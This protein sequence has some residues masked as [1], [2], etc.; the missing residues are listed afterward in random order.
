MTSIDDRRMN[1][2]VAAIDVPVDGYTQFVSLTTVWHF[3]QQKQ[4][5]ADLVREKNVAF[6][7]YMSALLI[8]R[9][10]QVTV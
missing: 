4:R 5:P 2:P 9:I 7:T 6:W 8:G 1:I 10:F 3:L